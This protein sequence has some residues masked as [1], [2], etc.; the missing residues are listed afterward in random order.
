M[1]LLPL[2]A[3]GE[4]D[5]SE[6]EATPPYGMTLAEDGQLYAGV[7]RIDVTPTD[8]ETFSD[9]NGDFYF[10]GC[11][12]T[13]DADRGGC[14]EPFDDANG[15]GYFDA[16][17]IA[18]FGSPRPAQRVA[19]P[20]TISAVVLSLDGEYVALVGVDA[21]GILENRIRDT[22]SLLASE[23]FD[24]DRVVIS[25]SHTHQGMDT[26]GIWGDIDATIIPG[27]YTPYVEAFAENVRDAIQTAAGSME[28]VSPTVGVSWMSSDPTLNGEPFGG[29]NPDPSLI[30][31]LNDIRD[32]LIAGDQVLAVALDGEAG[33]VAT[34][35]S[36]SGHP[37]VIG[38]EN[39][40]LS[41]DY[42]HY[43]REYI[44][45]RAGGT[46]V[47]LSGALGGMQSALGSTLPMVDDAGERVT[48]DAGAPSWDESGSGFEA[49]RQWGVLVAQAAEAAL[50]DAQA[51]DAISVEHTEFNVPVDNVDFRL[52]FSVGILDT[53]DEYVIQDESCPG[54]N[55]YGDVFGCIPLG[56]WVVRLGPVSLGTVPG[57][58]FPELFW[59]VP[60]EPSMADVSLRADDPRWVQVDR[61]CESVDWLTQCKDAQEAEVG[62]DCDGDGTECDGICDCL[63]SHVVPYAISDAGTTIADLL[64]GSYKAPIG[65]TNGYCGYI[66]PYPDFNT[67]A[68]QLSEDGDHYEETNS[69]TEDFA[70]LVLDAFTALAA[71]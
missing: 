28:P 31:G 61:D 36:A 63:G 7:A 49:A 55:G 20:L 68:S 29:I 65:I 34:V 53:P 25:S 50:S 41:S 35:V 1:L 52:A 32:P 44:E 18:G 64:D 62:T 51:W 56:V 19:D 22:R 66:V 4:P 15:N 10:D 40:A 38:D 3:C 17:Y 58:L 30:G 13:P 45:G 57:E 16:A 9:L 2:V 42:V 21:I 60:D 48:D 46:T 70:T 24:S 71:D 11:V 47:F 26:V 27:V 69:C 54:W 39:S 59:G 6:K 8:F 33:R 5:D 12:D 67:A 14:D 23:G 43:T 37:E